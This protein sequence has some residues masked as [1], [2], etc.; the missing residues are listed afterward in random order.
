M[1]GY[2][3]TWLTKDISKLNDEKLIDFVIDFAIPWYVNFYVS[4]HGLASN[5]TVNPLFIGYEDI[6]K[7]KK[8]EVSRIIREVG[9]AKVNLDTSLLE[10]D[11][12][13]EF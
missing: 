4:W 12:L 8:E 7:N 9:N 3:F 5:G 13:S 1:N 11:Y 2:S 6:M 10:K